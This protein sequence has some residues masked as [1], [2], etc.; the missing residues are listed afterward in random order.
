MDANI[1]VQG[2]K[3]ILADAEKAM[4][5]HLTHNANVYATEP[6]SGEG[7]KEERQ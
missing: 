2:I 1:I 4:A 5:R 3:A 7:R 6:R